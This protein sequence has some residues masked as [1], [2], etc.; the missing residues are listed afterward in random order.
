MPEVMKEQD[1]EMEIVEGE[2][3]GTTLEI[4]EEKQQQKQPDQ[5]GESD[6]DDD[7]DD[8]RHAESEEGQD[9]DER[10]AIRQR[11]REEKKER[12]RRRDEAMKRDK[13]ELEFLQRR[14][15][16]LEKRFSAVEQ[17]MQQTDIAAIDQRIAQVQARIKT[18][19]SVMAKAISANNG[20]DAAKALKIRDEAQQALYQLSNYRQAQMDLVQQGRQAQHPQGA[21]QA[22]QPDM[23]PPEQVRLAQDFLNRHKWYD[24]SGG[25]EASRIVLALDQA[26]TDEGRDASSPEYWKELERRIKL[27]VPEKFNDQRQQGGQERRSPSGGPQLG[28][29]RNGSSGTKQVYISPERKQAMIEAGVWDDPILRQKYIKRY[30]EYDKANQS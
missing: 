21:Q 11:R 22:Q 13:K 25:D 4:P 26:L 29:G 27:R 10:E 18:A 12:R 23:P 2:Q 8:D 19:E 15:E 16:E 28:S 6:D 7:D 30:M 9:D 3:P 20:E 1:E 5:S 17:R 14:N 24:P